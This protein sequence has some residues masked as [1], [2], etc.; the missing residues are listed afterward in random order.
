MQWSALQASSWR[1]G[2]GTD[3]L[4]L[5]P[6]TE[7]SKAPGA[8]AGAVVGHD[9]PGGEPE[10]LEVARCG[11]EDATGP[12]PVGARCGGRWPKAYPEG[13]RAGK[14]IGAGLAKTVSG[15]STIKRS[16]SRE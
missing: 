3:V 14:A 6:A 8:V 7:P 4:Q 13:N 16:R 15:R 12:A 2:P 9:P 11:E 10:G 5:Q 1:I